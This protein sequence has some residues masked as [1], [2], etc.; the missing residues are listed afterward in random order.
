MK[1]WILLFCAVL[2][3]TLTV[4]LPVVRAADAEGETGGF[5][6]SLTGGVLTVS[7]EGAMPDY[8]DGAPW[9]AYRDQ[10]TKVVF[11]G[12]VTYVGAYA[13]KD[14]DSLKE[15]DFGDAMYEL[16]KQAFYSCDGLTVLKLPATFKVFG[17]ECLRHCSGLREIHDAGRPASF[18]L[19]CL[20]DTKVI[21]YYPAAQPWGL[22][23]IMEMEEVFKGRIEFRASDGTDPYDPNAVTTEPSTEPTTEPTTA[24]TT[25]PATEPTEETLPAQTVPAPTL[26]QQTQP[27]QTQPTQTAPTQPSTPDNGNG[28][29]SGGAW[30]WLVVA[31]FFALLAMTIPSLI[32]PKRRKKRRSTNRYS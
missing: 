14:Y 28:S 16:G 3:L 18:R 8:P 17:E 25:E 32:K 6:W 21:I 30:V 24:P 27:T 11:S 26:P 2:C 29:R 4:Q 1:K 10:I 5:T 19:N 7:G 9:D 20:W 13:F 23:Y 22:D 15:V 31:V 12:G